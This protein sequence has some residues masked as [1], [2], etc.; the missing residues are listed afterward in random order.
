MLSKISY[1]NFN[2]VLKVANFRLL[3]YGAQVFSC[4]IEDYNLSGSNG[5]I[6]RYFRSGG[7]RTRTGDT[8]IFSRG[9]PR[10]IIRYLQGKREQSSNF[11]G[12]VTAT[13][14]LG[15]QTLEDPLVI[16]A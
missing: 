11:D 5:Q 2:S 1:I 10:S 4:H 14:F 12:N 7:T 9:V 15:V 8:M 3:A 16:F 13:C 6:C